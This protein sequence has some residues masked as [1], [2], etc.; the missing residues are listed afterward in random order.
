MQS[1]AWANDMCMAGCK[2]IIASASVVTAA[3]SLNDES[4]NLVASELRVGTADMV[5][6]LRRMDPNRAVHDL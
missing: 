3:T 1:P 2:L 5:R 4:K 6:V